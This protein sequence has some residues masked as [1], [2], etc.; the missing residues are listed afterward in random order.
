MFTAHKAATTE[1]EQQAAKQAAAHLSWQEATEQK[2]A[3][4]NSLLAE[5]R[6][7]NLTARS[8][9]KQLP[10]IADKF[11]MPRN[12]DQN[13]L[14]Y[15]RAFI[16]EATAI[17]TEFTNRGLPA[18]FL[19]DMQARID[20]VEAG[21]SSQANALAEKA[22]A[23]ANIAAALKRERDI[24]RELN[25]VVR[26]TFRNDPGLLAAWKSASH[27]EKAPKRKKETEEAG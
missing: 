17:P 4:I 25:A 26:N 12:S 3:A 22:A 20:A 9:D 27:I 8:I 11:R 16:Q 5:M 18:S 10:G 13:V 14:N 23:T 6:A 7:I 19:T 15:A 2:N 24:M 1:V 21:E